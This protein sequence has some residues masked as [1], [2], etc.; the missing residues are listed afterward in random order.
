[1]P[2]TMRNDHNISTY[3]NLPDLPDSSR[4]SNLPD[5]LHETTDDVQKNVSLLD[6]TNVM[7]DHL[8]EILLN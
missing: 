6:F 2:T 8:M 4:F 3:M 7:F 5:F 1:M